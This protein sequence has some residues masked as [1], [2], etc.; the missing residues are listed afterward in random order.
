MTTQPVTIIESNGRT[1][2]VYRDDASS[3][4]P[5]DE[6]ERE[7]V[8]RGEVYRY[9]EVDEHG[10]VVPGGQS[11]SRLIGLAW[12]CEAATGWRYAPLPAGASAMHCPTC[13]VER[14][15]AMPASCPHIEV[16][17]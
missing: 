15:V 7:M 5:V 6:Y 1:Y 10:A 17:P 14:G 11:C 13:A 9:V 3:A 8:A 4:E 2:A 12:A 16:Q